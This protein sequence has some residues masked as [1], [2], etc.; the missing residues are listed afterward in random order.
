MNSEV[1][2]H[3]RQNNPW[4]KLP[5]NVKQVKIFIF[6]VY[7]YIYIHPELSRT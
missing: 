7:K 5:E 2:F 3:V 4:S 1:E 6:L